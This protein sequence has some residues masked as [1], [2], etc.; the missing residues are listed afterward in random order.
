[1]SRL[2]ARQGALFAMVGVCATAVHVIVALATREGLGL[3]PMQ[4]NLVAYACAVGVSYVGNARFTF[5]RPTLHAPQFVRFVVVSLAGLAA[6]QAI[7]WL[8]VNRLGWPFWLGLA[9]VVV[10]VPAISFLA[11]RAWAFADPG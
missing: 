11:A 8:L 9:V 7:T 2:I 1:V 10:V 5:L 6:N 3:G 4:A